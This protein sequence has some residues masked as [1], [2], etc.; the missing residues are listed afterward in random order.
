MNSDDEWSDII[1]PVCRRAETTKKGDWF[2]LCSAPGCNKGGHLKCFKIK[3]LPEGDWFCKD[4]SNSGPD[5]TTYGLQRGAGNNNKE[6]FRLRH[7]LLPGGVATRSEVSAVYE[8]A[9]AD[10]TKT[11][12]EAVDNRF[13]SFIEEKRGEDALPTSEDVEEFGTTMVKRGLVSTTIIQEVTTILQLY[14][15]LE[16]GINRDRLFRGIERL[17]EAPSN[18]KMPIQT[19]ELVALLSATQTTVL[20]AS[21]SDDERTHVRARDCAF[22]ML[23]FM[24]MLRGAELVALQWDDITLQWDRL[25]RE[26]SLEGAAAHT[27]TA[28]GMSI[29]IVTSKTDKASKGETILIPAGD[30]QVCPV[31]SVR[32]LYELRRPGQHAVFA[33]VRAKQPPKALTTDTMRRRFAQYAGTFL[34]DERVKELSLHSFRKG[35]ASA[36]LDAGADIL[37]IRRQG[38]WAAGSEVS[39]QYALASDQAVLGVGRKILGKLKQ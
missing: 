33:D 30:D 10:A 19:T 18:G 12:K 4:C 29:R 31:R 7:G 16:T 21:F 26:T 15:E 25:P 5:T 13:K 37:T 24:G 39:L 34:S 22:F 27:G 8:A 14:P 11:R 38:R 3:K 17:A 1:C 35:G 9:D 23:A 28:T 2:L 6:A 20:E 32:R 36:A